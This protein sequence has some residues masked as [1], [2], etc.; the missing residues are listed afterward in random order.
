MKRILLLITSVS[1]NAQILSTS[2]IESGSYSFSTNGNPLDSYSQKILQYRTD[3]HILLT[4]VNANYTRFYYIKKGQMITKYVDIPNAYTVN[5]YSILGD[6]L[7]FCGS[8]PYDGSTKGFIAYISVEDLFNSSN[9][10]NLCKYTLIETTLSV[11][12]IKTY[13]NSIGERIVA[14]IGNQYYGDPP[15][16]DYILDPMGTTS[17]NSWVFP[18]SYYY[19][20]FI[21]Y[22][23][24]ESLRTLY[25]PPITTYALAN[26]VY[27]YHPFNE[28]SSLNTEKFQDII[29]NDNY[30][31]LASTTVFDNGYPMHNSNIILREF[32]KNSF[33][34]IAN[35]FSVSPDYGHADY[36]FKLEALDKNKIALAHVLCDIQNG[37]T[38]DILYKINLDSNP[39]NFIQSSMIDSGANRYDIY[40]IEY[41]KEINQ[42]LMLKLTTQR[43][44]LY[45]LNINDN[46]G[47]PYNATVLKIPYAI[48][49][50]QN[51]S[52]LLKYS[53]TYFV[54][55]GS[56]GSEI[57]LFDKETSN[58]YNEDCKE[59]SDAVIKKLSNPEIAQ[60]L[61]LLQCSF[62]GYSFHSS[63]LPPDYTPTFMSN[64]IITD[65]QLPTPTIGNVNTRCETYR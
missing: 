45:Y 8:E 6:T 25:D 16:I 54:M 65:I 13:Y 49:P 11:K 64:A 4:K 47:F 2:N 48:Y 19:E 35:N 58:L 34:Q 28:L 24:V 12:K 22:K 61:D 60:G 10:T 36:G 15:Y 52:N 37:T 44:A 56:I 29:I 23:V 31:C 18:Q 43:D 21:V 39:F 26:S 53:S 57:A 17:T 7:Y 9:P 41:L 27:I 14:G 20:C 5:D 40:D 63:G 51:W 33:V 55:I 32:D 62:P 38:K 3:V 59:L 30:I 1:I 46:V 42:L 50:V